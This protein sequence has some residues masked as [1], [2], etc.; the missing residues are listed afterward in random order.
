MFLGTIILP[1][2][3]YGIVVLFVL[4]LRVPQ[5]YKYQQNNNSLVDMDYKTVFCK[6]S[7]WTDFI[8]V[9][10]RKNKKGRPS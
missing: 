2:V 7:V 10:V 1:L 3:P 4:S 8:F 6:N 5:F 9:G